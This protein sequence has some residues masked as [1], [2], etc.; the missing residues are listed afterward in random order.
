MYK[1]ERDCKA[2]SECVTHTRNLHTLAEVVTTGSPH[3][4]TSWAISHRNRTYGGFVDAVCDKAFVVPCWIS[5]LGT[6]PSSGSFRITQ[7]IV[8]WCLILAETA[9]ACIR[10]RAFFTASG[11]PAP[12]V[13]GL[14]FSTSAVKV[15]DF[16]SVTVARLGSFA[17]VI[18][19]PF[20]QCRL[21]MW[22][23]QS[24]LLKWLAQL[25]SFSA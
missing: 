3:S 8:L 21:I 1:E 2:F 12:P 19:H 7:C 10:F 23:R 13:V 14:D 20:C 5:L 15:R 25:C 4:L 17:H 24:R 16:T 18:T 22:V 6:V 9:S 11:I